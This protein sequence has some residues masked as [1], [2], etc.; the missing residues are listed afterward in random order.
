MAGTAPLCQWRGPARAQVARDLGSA[1]RQHAMARAREHDQFGIRNAVG[2][3]L[4]VRKRAI[5]VCAAMDHER[6]A[7]HLCQRAALVGAADRLP[8]PRHRAMVR[9]LAQPQPPFAAG[10]GF[11]QC[12]RCRGLEPSHRVQLRRAGN[13]QQFRG[14]RLSRMLVRTGKIIQRHGNA[15]AP[16]GQHERAAHVAAERA[17]QHFGA[18][19]ERASPRIGRWHRLAASGQVGQDEGAA[20]GQLPRQ[21][22]P[23]AAR[24]LYAM[25]RNHR[26]RALPCDQYVIFRHDASPNTSNILVG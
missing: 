8:C 11:Q 13:Q 9:C 16:S 22:H 14:H 19:I 20:V 26:H 15:H 23:R 12:P 18:G 17:A 2:Q 1:L 4:A 3:P 6:P 25:H 21:R 5:L 24:A 7:T 10:N